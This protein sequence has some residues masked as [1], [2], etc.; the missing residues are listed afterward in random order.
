M[1]N[2]NTIEARLFDAINKHPMKLAKQLKSLSLVNDFEF[3][4]RTDP[5]PLSTAPAEN[6]IVI[7][8]SQCARSVFI[9][10]INRNEITFSVKQFSRIKKRDARQL[11]KDARWGNI[12]YRP[13]TRVAAFSR[14]ETRT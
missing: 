8:A 11:F 9:Q 10:L 3:R 6:C 5:S 12:G 14:L 7:D 13:S 1:L 4:G 2:G